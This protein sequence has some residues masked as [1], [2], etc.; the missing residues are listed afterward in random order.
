MQLHVEEQGT[1]PAVVVLHGAPSPTSELAPLVERLRATHRV[2]VPSMP[3][4]GTSPR[5]TP[6]TATRLRDA[7][8]ALLIARDA[9]RTAI[10]GYS[11]GALH[12]SGLALD[13]RLDITH[14]VSLAG[15][16][17]LGEDAAANA[18]MRGFISLLRTGPDLRAP[19][20]KAMAA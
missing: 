20:W 5:L 3:G 8:V 7:L 18:E 9:R 6:Y 1:G 16:A 12:A 14:V 2:L 10:V 17:G 11:M 19:E 15:H 4:Y 13:P